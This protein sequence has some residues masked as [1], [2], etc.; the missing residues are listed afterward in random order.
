M[1]KVSIII[2]AY[3]VESYICKCLDSVIKQTFK[4][5][6]IIVVNDGSTDNTLK[7]IKEKAGIDNRIKIIDKRN[8][9]LIEARK[10]GFKEATGEYV[11]F[12]DG[13]DWIDEHTV[14]VLYNKAKSEDYD[15][16][17]YKLL[18]AYSD[19][20]LKK[21]YSKAFHILK[22][23]EFLELCLTDSIP[24]GICSKFIKR[25]FIVINN[26]EFPSNISYAE[27][28]ALTCTLAMYK[29]KVCELGEHLYYY[30]QRDTSLT[31]LISSKMLEISKATEFIKEQLLKNNLLDLYKEEFEY[32]AFIYNYYERRKVIF[33]TNSD[34]SYTMYKN[35]KDMN[36]YIYNN[37][38]YK[39]LFSKDSLINKI[40]T[41]LCQSNY[42]IGRILYRFVKV[43]NRV[44]RGC[45]RIY[46]NSIKLFSLKV[47]S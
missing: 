11:L 19:G 34:I 17:G 2:A 36:V 40:A 33:D 6:E 24:H 25:D 15:I 7:E 37:K 44:K 42:T 31:N 10:S 27:D 29:P 18:I 38:Y 5:I 16:V 41:K 13:D 9:G 47:D 46:V 45:K 14:E 35:W 23:N 12:I 21:N 30:Y 4:E 20:T 8:E 43:T 32:L 3:N 39:R 22:G 26:I 28:L 1:I